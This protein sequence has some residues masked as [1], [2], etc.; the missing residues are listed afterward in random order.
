MSKVLVISGHPN[1]EASYTNKVI[2]EQAEKNVHN[3]EVR[4]LDTLYPDYRINI[5]AEQQA[6]LNADVIVLQ[7][8]FYWYSVPALLKKWIDDVFSY[9]FAYGS[10]GDKLKGKDFLLSFT[11][12]GPSESY[13][14][15]GYNH[16][17]IEQLMMPLQQT[18]YLAG[19][20]FQKPLYTHGMVF[21]PGVYN[22]QED[23]ETKAMEHANTLVS[24]I[25]ALVDSTE[26]R[27]RKLVKEWFAKLDVLPENGD[28]FLENLSANIAWFAPEGEFNGHAG[29]NDWYQTVRSMFKPDCQ[30]I[31]EDVKVFENGSDI[32]AELRIR[33][34]AETFDGESINLLVNETWNLAVQDSKLVITRYLVEPL[35]G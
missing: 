35:Q 25:D 26:N 27:V 11:I 3:V 32:K 1:L 10:K 7:F 2:L 22:T 29:F 12:G 18:A 9:N 8:P 20:N 24:R 14:P 21:I 34:I 13:E 31:V 33:L 17:S 28:Y 30:H 6:L 15:L 4:R 19:M 23:V 5:E 16:F